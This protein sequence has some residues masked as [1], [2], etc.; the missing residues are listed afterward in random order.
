[1]AVPKQKQSHA[2]TS[3]RRAQHKISAP[4]LNACPQCHQPRRLTACAR[5][6]GPTRVA[7]SWRCATRTITT[8]TT[9]SVREPVAVAVGAN[10]ADHGP[11]GGGR[12]AAPPAERGPPVLL[13]G[14]AAEIGEMPE[15]VE[16]IDAPVSIAKAQDPARAVRANPD[17]SIVAAVSAVADGRAEALVSGGSTGT[18][19]AASLFRIKRGRGIHRPAL[20][21]LVPVPGTPFLLLD[22]G[23]NVEVRPEH[24]VQFAH[25]GAAFMETAMG[26]PRPRVGLLSNGE[27]ASK[28]PEDLVAAHTALSDAESGLNFVGNVEG[29]AIGTGEADVIVTDGFTGNV[30]LKVMEGTSAVL[31]GAVREAATSSKRSTIGGLLLR[32]ALRELRD[33]LDPQAVGG[34]VLLGLRKLVVVPHGSFEAAGITN[35]IDLA[36]RG[37]R[38][39]VV[40]RTLET[41][42][43]AGALRRAPAEVSAL[44]ST[45]PDQP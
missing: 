35:A 12:G 16:V 13:F 26:L 15:G 19:L 28:G 1:M 14:P 4:S 36:A 20:A 45:V 27:E 40:G 8:T 29:F 2:R 25:M 31:L 39:D 7:R 10:G 11:G 32:P 23:A 34:A 33:Q 44:A 3:K 41:L 5:T 18:A 43:A 17:A 22:A 24:L 38:E 42:A 37:V 9:S 6:A 30:A 21:V